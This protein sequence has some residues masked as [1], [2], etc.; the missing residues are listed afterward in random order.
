MRDKCDKTPFDIA[1]EN[2]KRDVVNFLLVAKRE[3]PLG[4]RRGYPVRS[5]SLGVKL[6]YSLPEIE[7]VEPQLSCGNS[8]DESTSLHSAI[9]NGRTDMVQRLLDHGAEVDERDQFLQTPLDVASMEGKLDHARTLIKYGA[10]VNSRDTIGWTP[11]H[12]ATRYGHVDI[13]RLLLDNGADVNAIQRDCATPLHIASCNVY[14][15]IV[16]L[17]LDRG[18]NVQLRNAYGR[19]PSQEASKGAKRVAQLFSEYGVRKE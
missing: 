2:G 5:A 15:E 13:A 10:D 9:A 14:P 12:T 1:L 6:Q 19:T 11:L 3:G 18:A 17:L 7:T 8:P 4:S 16:Q